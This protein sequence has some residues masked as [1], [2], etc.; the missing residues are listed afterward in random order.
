MQGFLLAL[1]LFYSEAFKAH[2]DSLLEAGN[3]I[4][5]LK[6][7]EDSFR[8]SPNKLDYEKLRVYVLAYQGSVF[9]A[10]NAY[11]RLYTATGRHEPELLHWI[12]LGIFNT[13]NEKL[14]RYL[15]FR[16][17]LIHDIE[18]EKPI[19]KFIKRLDHSERP[20]FIR[21]LNKI[22]DSNVFMDVIQ[23][24]REASTHSEVFE[25]A[26]LIS[27]L[28]IST[29]INVVDTLLSDLNP[30]STAIALWV[31]GDMLSPPGGIF[32]KYT[33]DKNEI[34]S[35]LAK[36]GKL[37]HMPN[38]DLSLIEPY[39]RSQ[40]PEIKK[41]L[42]F[43]LGF[44]GTKAEPILLALLSDSN[45]EVKREAAKSLFYMGSERA[46]APYI[47]AIDYIDP[48][49]KIWG[50][51]NLAQIADSSVVPY[52][53]RAISTSPY[54]AV[55]IH[56][57]WALAM[58]G[59]SGAKKIL[60]SLMNSSNPLIK[61]EASLALGY[62]GDSRSIIQITRLARSNDK[63]LKKRALWIL[64]KLGDERGYKYLLDGLTDESLDI[65]VVSAL[66]LWRILNNSDR[67]KVRE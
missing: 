33:N 61:Q 21:N 48:K 53:A 26:P 57:I 28:S 37:K 20:F 3:Y 9:K 34:I 51:D 46:L 23:L 63:N 5:A 2:I 11:M 66:G 49:K 54:P 36:I 60:L 16:L 35:M 65:R 4:E 8:Q 17:A 7:V 40:V 32:A 22:A 62:M 56:G 12:A 10:S 30:Y 47:Q 43:H 59:G 52:I 27:R 50:I 42:A 29:G 58:L 39:A 67:V 19:V 15:A 41:I 44:F 55:K 25:L 38:P 64:C 13:D 31:A 24:A 14:A 45:E 18:A 6:I 1:F